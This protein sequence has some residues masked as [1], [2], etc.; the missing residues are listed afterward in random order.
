[1]IWRMLAICRAGIPITPCLDAIQVVPQRM[2]TNARQKMALAL[3]PFFRMVSGLNTDNFF[4]V[5]AED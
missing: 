5:S 2:Q 4:N 1:M 3:A